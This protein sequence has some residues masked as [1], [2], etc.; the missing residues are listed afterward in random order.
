MTHWQGYPVPVMRY[1][2]HYGDR[3]VRCFAE[4]PKSFHAMFAD[5]LA[6]KPDAQALA[7]EGQ[8]WT[9]A[10]CDGI[11]RKLATGLVEHGIGRGDRI[12]KV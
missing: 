3:L 1:E 2:A 9:Y 6:R 8:F 11:T 12:L 4:R 7:F 10:E 5:T